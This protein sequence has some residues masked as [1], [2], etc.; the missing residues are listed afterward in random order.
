MRYTSGMSKYTAL[1]VAL[2]TLL[3]CTLGSTVAWSQPPAFHEDFQAMPDWTPFLLPDAKRHAN[4]TIRNDSEPSYLHAE[5]EGAAS[6]L[7]SPWTTPLT[8][9]TVLAWRWRIEQVPEEADLTRKEGDDSPLRVC[10]VF[11]DEKQ[12]MS[13]ERLE[14]GGSIASL[15]RETPRLIHYAWDASDTLAGPSPNPHADEICVVPVRSGREGLGEWREERRNLAADY[16]RCFDQEPRR[17]VRVVIASDMDNTG[18]HGEASLDW[19]ELRKGHDAD[20]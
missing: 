7:C 15:F 5:T 13:P 12:A 14:E 9:M 8:K 4:F 2:L 3:C 1:H 18:G 10:A 11:A 20:F 19:I 17:L 6:G 16:R